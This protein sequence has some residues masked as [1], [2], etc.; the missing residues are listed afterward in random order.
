MNHD[1][2]LSTVTSIRNAMTTLGIATDPSVEA[3]SANLE[4]NLLQLCRGVARMRDIAVPD[5][6]V[7]LF[8]IRHRETGEFRKAGYG[9][10]GKKGKAWTSPNHVKGHLAMVRQAKY[11]SDLRRTVGTKYTEDVSAWEVIEYRA[12]VTIVTPV[13]EFYPETTT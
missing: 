5:P 13:L 6:S 3:F 8:R 4:S 10:W 1:F 7:R 2:R 12:D 9:S 11:D